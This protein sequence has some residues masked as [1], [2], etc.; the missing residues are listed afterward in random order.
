MSESNIS[1][2]PVDEAQPV[3]SKATAGGRQQNRRVEIVAGRAGGAGTGAA[4]ATD[5]NA[6]GSR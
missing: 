3:A 1:V 6:A 5:S 2:H 4:T